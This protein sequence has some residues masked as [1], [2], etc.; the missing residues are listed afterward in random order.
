MGDVLMSTAAVHELRKQHKNAKIIYVTNKNNFPILEDNPDIDIVTDVNQ[1]HPDKLV[2]FS[3]P[4]HEGY[5]NVPMSKH[6]AEYFADNAGVK[7]PDDWNYILNVEQY[8]IDIH[9]FQ[10]DVRDNQA[11]IQAIDELPLEWQEIDILINNAGLAVG[12]EKLYEGDTE[13]WERMLDTN[14]KG[15]LYVSRQVIPLMV[16]RH[17]GHIVNIGSV[18]GHEPYPGGAVYCASK[19]AVRSISRALKMD[20]LGTNIR[21]SSIDPGMVETE[22]SMVRFKGNTSKADSVYHGLAPLTAEDIADAIVY[23]TSRPAHVN[24][25]EMLILPT[26]QASATMSHRQ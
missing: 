11:V 1:H 21:V 17:C 20:L 14:I 5:P 26:A 3:Y 6:L 19:S 2:S 8:D 7:L 18:A 13:D 16:K 15:L 24:I 22:F 4:M 23:C 12:L 9:C 10:L 25:Q